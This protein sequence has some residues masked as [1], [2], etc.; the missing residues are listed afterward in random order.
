MKNIQDYFLKIKSKIYANQMQNEGSTVSVNDTKKLI[1][2]KTE[3]CEITEDFGV[4]Y[5][6]L[7]MFSGLDNAWEYIFSNY[8]NI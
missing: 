5:N 2:L 3:N 7:L 8:N 6:D 4:T 1:T